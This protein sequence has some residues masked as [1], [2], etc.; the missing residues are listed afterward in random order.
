MHLHPYIVDQLAE[1]HHRQLIALAQAERLTR[2]K[3]RR[4]E[5]RTPGARI[6]RRFLLGDRP[7][8][9]TIT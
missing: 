9:T 1:Q 3:A 2:R 7:C 4:A 8:T 6:S 5:R